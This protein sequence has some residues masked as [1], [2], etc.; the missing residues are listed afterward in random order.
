MILMLSILTL[1]EIEEAI[2]LSLGLTELSRSLGI[3]LFLWLTPYYWPD[4]Y[5]WKCYT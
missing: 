3:N 5:P 4:F 2:L 1:P